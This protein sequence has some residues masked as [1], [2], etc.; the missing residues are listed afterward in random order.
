MRVC[1]EKHVYLVSF[2]KHM[3]IGT[4]IRTPCTSKQVAELYLGGK[5]DLVVVSTRP[6]HLKNQMTYPR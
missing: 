4:H 5:K 3:Q 2:Y 1:H 6:P